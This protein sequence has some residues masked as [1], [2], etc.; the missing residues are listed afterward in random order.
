MLLDI[1]AGRVHFAFDNLASLLA[2]VQQGQIHPLAITSKERSQ[3]LPDVPT[4]NR[5]YLELEIT[6][7]AGLIRAGPPSGADR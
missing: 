6:S 3:L 1:I 4:T 5:V 7:W 2:P